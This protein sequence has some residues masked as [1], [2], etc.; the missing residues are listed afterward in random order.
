MLVSY[1]PTSSPWGKMFSMYTY[2]AGDVPGWLTEN[3][4]L[5]ALPGSE[6]FF[7]KTALGDAIDITTVLFYIQGLLYDAFL[8]HQSRASH[9]HKTYYDR[10]DL[11]QQLYLTG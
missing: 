11:L 6:S 9:L 7:P 5:L 10:G 4:V 1:F 8:V 2:S 3:A